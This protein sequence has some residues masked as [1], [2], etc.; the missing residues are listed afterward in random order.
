ML[1]DDTITEEAWRK[2][3]NSVFG[4]EFGWFIVNNISHR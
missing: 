3:S 4:A 2:I 1:E